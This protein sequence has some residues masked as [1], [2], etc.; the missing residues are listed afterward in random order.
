[1]DRSY[2]A[3]KEEEALVEACLNLDI[4]TRE[5]MV[6]IELSSR[7]YKEDDTLFMTATMIAHSDSP[8]PKL[9]AIAFVLT[10]KQLITV[11]YIEPK[12]FIL[13]ISQLQKRHTTHLHATTL[14]VD[15]LDI[16][17]DRLADI[18][19]LIGHRLDES[20]KAIFRPQDDNEVKPDYKEFMQQ[21]GI[22]SAPQINRTT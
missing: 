16:N 8:E 17:V 3:F 18:L 21:I 9:D 2:F 15:L 14:L 19:E 1:M 4:P 11:R 10:K 6:E 5:E 7:L 13:F 22:C 12:S 20:S